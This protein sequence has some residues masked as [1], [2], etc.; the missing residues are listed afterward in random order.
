MR[1]VFK[2]TQCHPNRSH[3]APMSGIREKNLNEVS[4]ALL[5]Q[6]CEDLTEVQD[7]KQNI[8]DVTHAE[9]DEQNLAPRKE[10]DIQVRKQ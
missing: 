10:V 8:S 4:L 6:R 7:E 1:R 3:L 5:D 2:H 9:T